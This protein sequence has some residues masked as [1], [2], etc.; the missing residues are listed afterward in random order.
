MIKENQPLTL[1]LTITGTLTNATS[2]TVEWTAPNGKTGSATATLS[3]TAAT[4]V[5]A[6]PANILT[7]V[8]EWKT[9]PVVAY[10]NGDFIPGTAWTTTIKRRFA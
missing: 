9:I 5:Y 7:P 10:S 4:V 6:F 8:G 2:A 3:I 1:T